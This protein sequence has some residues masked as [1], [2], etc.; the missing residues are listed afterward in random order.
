M[1][2]S[3]A[4][5]ASGRTM[6]SIRRC[7][8]GNGGDYRTASGSERVNGLPPNLLHRDMR[9]GSR[10]LIPLATAR[11]S[12]K[13]RPLLLGR[14]LWWAGRHQLA[15]VAAAFSVGTIFRRALL[16]SLFEQK[17]LAALRTLLLNRLVPEYGVAL[18]II[19]AAVE[20]F[21]AP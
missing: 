21:S 12:V 19:R 3:P 6:W 18:R 17:R 7:I 10:I 9:R 8:C 16:G 11:G 13:S 4:S 5:I 20:N 2:K 14:L 15:F 1:K